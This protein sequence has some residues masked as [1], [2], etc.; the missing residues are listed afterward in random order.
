MEVPWHAVALGVVWLSVATRP[1]ATLEDYDRATFDWLVFALGASAACTLAR[2][3]WTWCFG[4][5]WFSH[6]SLFFGKLDDTSGRLVLPTGQ[7]VSSSK[8]VWVASLEQAYFF[9]YTLLAFC[10]LQSANVQRRTA[11]GACPE[12]YSC[13]TG[14]QTCNTTS[15]EEGDDGPVVCARLVSDWTPEVVRVV[16]V[17]AF[18]HWCLKQTM[19]LQWFV[20][21]R[22]LRL[23]A[24][25]LPWALLA[26]SGAGWL[27]GYGQRVCNALSLLFFAHYSPAHVLCMFA[28]F[29]L[30]NLAGSVLL[31]VVREEK[32]EVR[33]PDA[34]DAANTPRVRS[35][36]RSSGK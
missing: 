17:M 1:L 33:L 12:G 6:L 25:D 20:A 9:C 24:H 14:S 30:C 15:T 32:K 8:L 18:L 11:L 4:L 13:F 27:Q 16:V 28:L 36:S 31:F 26:V 7:T 35:R 19:A 3:A 2:A 29:V 10:L 22:P 34:A 21:R 5:P 23:G